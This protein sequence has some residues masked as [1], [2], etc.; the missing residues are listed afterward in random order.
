[1]AQAGSISVGQIIFY[2]S[3]ITLVSDQID[4]L[5]AEISNLYS[6]NLRLNDIRELLEYPQEIDN[7][8]KQLP[9]L[10]G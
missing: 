3:A 9:R 7:S 1:L 8:K 4:S 10:Q 2:I 6:I 5:S